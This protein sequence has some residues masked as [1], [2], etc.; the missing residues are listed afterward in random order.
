MDKS[1]SEIPGA[2]IADVQLQLYN[3]DPNSHHAHHNPCIN[4][5]LPHVQIY[6][7]GSTKSSTPGEVMVYLGCNKM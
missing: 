4:Q 2:G 7:N 3:L 5:E 1:K 6:G